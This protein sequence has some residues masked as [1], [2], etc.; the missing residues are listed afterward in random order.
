M[1]FS[2]FANQLFIAKTS[3]LCCKKIYFRHDDKPREKNQMNK[4][5]ICVNV[6]IRNFFEDHSRLLISFFCW[7]YLI[8]L[9]ITVEFWECFVIE[10]SPFYSSGQKK[11]WV[12]E[13]AQK[14]SIFLRFYFCRLHYSHFNRLMAQA[15]TFPT[16]FYKQ[17]FF[18][19]GSQEC[20][21]PLITIMS[22]NH[23]NVSRFHPYCCYFAY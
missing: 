20:F 8:I 13:R 23:R 5:A 7:L 18:G 9:I 4:V 1:F 3:C 21:F 14:D 2:W 10:D 11:I 15:R 6:Q 12:E 22:L 19:L 16:N 17:I